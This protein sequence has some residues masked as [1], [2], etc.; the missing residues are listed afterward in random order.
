M[1]RNGT[2]QVVYIIREEVSKGCES[3]NGKTCGTEP[4]VYKASIR[5]KFYSKHLLFALANIIYRHP[6]VPVAS[7]NTEAGMKGRYKDCH[8]WSLDE[9]LLYR[10]SYALTREFGLC[11]CQ[12]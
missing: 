6:A 2:L 5:D 1:R 8:H 4:P 3:T 7:K 10:Q 9:Q 11:S 12:N